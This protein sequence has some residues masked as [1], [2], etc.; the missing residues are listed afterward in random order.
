MVLLSVGFKGVGEKRRGEGWGW[1]A[2]IDTAFLHA[3]CLLIRQNPKSGGVFS[4]MVQKHTDRAEKKHAFVLRL[5]HCVTRLNLGWRV[6][7]DFVDQL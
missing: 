6:F 3:F 7:V 2:A 5:E 1:E 4:G